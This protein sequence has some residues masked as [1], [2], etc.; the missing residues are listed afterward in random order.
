M[1]SPVR[2]NVCGGPV[3]SEDILEENLCELWG[4]Y[5]RPRG[6][7]VGHFSESVHYYQY[8]VESVGDW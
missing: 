4:I 6:D 8:C 2:D 1:F 5:V 7:E 3:F